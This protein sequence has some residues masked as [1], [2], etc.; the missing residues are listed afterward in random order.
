MDEK[1]DISVS[2]KGVRPVLVAVDF[3]SDSKAAL[4]WGLK[5]AALISAPDNCFACYPRSS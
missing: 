4:I 3:S 5:H 1:S 2:A